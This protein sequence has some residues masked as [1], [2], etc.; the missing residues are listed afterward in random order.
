MSVL[1]RI[2]GFVQLAVAIAAGAAASQAPAFLHQYRQN[3]AGRLAE[4]RADVDAI[5]ARAMEARLPVQGYIDRLLGNADPIVTGEARA[6]LAKIDHADALAAAQEALAAAPPL[7]RPLV[8]LGHFD[9]G[10]AASTWA[11]FQPAVP[12][13]W[14]SLLY[15]AAGLAIGWLA[16]HGIAKAAKRARRRQAV[17]R[18]QDAYVDG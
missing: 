5:L 17:R 13:D 8:L 6:L 10:I 14:A 3:L 11:H 4:A 9:R 15:A 1:G 12:I 7:V 18:G 2:G 16:C